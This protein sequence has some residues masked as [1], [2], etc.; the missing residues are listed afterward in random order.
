M[1]QLTSFD[2]PK[3]LADFLAEEIYQHMRVSPLGARLVLPG[4]TTPVFL[5]EALKAKSWKAFKFEV[6]ATDERLVEKSDP[7]R[8]EAAIDAI[9]S[10]YP[11]IRL[12][13]LALEHDSPDA[14]VRLPAC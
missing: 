9:F 14:L 13:T 1:L 4:G 5:Y 8:N 7:R 12:K 11:E 2:S 6:M 3:K 10:S